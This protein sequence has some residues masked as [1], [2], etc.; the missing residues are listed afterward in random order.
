MEYMTQILACTLGAFGYALVYNVKKDKLFAV[1]IGGFLT[2]TMYVIGNEL[3]N[4][5][6]LA[7]TI[8]SAALTFYSEILA[9]NL[10]SP[11]TVFLMPGIIPLVPGGGLFYTM[12]GLL[13]GNDIQF[14]AYKI[15]TFEATA[16]I[17]IGVII[18]SLIFQ[19]IN[20]LLAKKLA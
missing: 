1:A 8:S 6:F 12:T 14:E 16:G 2:I 11:A 17:A 3:L 5:V 20:R 15:S 10:K 19:H 9:R 7:T 13:T 18:A 4:D